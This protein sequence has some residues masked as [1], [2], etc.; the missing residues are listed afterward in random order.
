MPVTF[1]VLSCEQGQICAVVGFCGDAFP[2]DEAKIL[3]KTHKLFFNNLL[4]DCGRG[5]KAHERPYNFKMAEL[6][7]ITE[8][9]LGRKD[10]LPGITFLPRQFYDK[11]LKMLLDNPKLEGMFDFEFCFFFLNGITLSSTLV[12]LCVW[13][14][15]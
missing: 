15:R 5:C 3:A 9:S 7:K 2:P 4:G 1:G 6:Y 14:H 11:L 13:C 12:D 8:Q 10:G